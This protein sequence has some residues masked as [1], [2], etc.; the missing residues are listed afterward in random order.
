MNDQLKFITYCGLY[1][2]LCSARARIPQQA[3]A[4]R[5]SMDRE[6]YPYWGRTIPGFEPFWQFLED[7]SDIDKACPGCRQDGGDPGCEI[8][9]CTRERQVD[10]CAFCNDFPCEKIREFAKTYPTLIT[11]GERMK[12]IGIDAWIA[13]Q[14]K[15]AAAGFVYTDIRIGR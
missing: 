14:E 10:I 7:L 5:E 13:E 15:R 1:C 3:Q 4:L 9:V 2:G 12:T 6:G 11:D 8:R